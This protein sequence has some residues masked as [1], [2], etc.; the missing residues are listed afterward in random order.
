MAC[1]VVASKTVHPTPVE[2]QEVELAAQVA[3]GNAQAARKLYACYAAGLTSVCARYIS[4]DDDLHDILQESFLQIFSSIHQFHY[5][6]EGSLRAWM[7]RIVANKSIDFLKHQSRMNLFETTDRL[8]DSVSEDEDVD[9]NE[10][11][12][13]TLH[14]LIRNLPIGYRTVFNLYVFEHLSHREIA[15]R[16]NIREASSASQLHRA[17]EMLARQIKELTH[18]AETGR[19]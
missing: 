1:S 5:Q 19:P 12:L 7:S 17:K 2:H 14:D 4:N 15:S 13:Q 3:R 8:P 9:V 10:L 6:G 11:S 16:L 18:H